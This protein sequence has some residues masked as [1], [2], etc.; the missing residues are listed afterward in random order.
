MRLQE[1]AV[2]IFKI[3]P[4]RSG[5]KKAI[6]RKEILLNGNPAKTSDWIETGQ[7]IE[8]LQ[9]E[10]K[11]KKIYKLPLEVLFEDE[12]L[13]IINKPS[14]IPTSGNYFKTLE[15]TLPF[16]LKTSKAKAALPYALPVHRLDNPTSG[17][18]ICA[19]TRISLTKLQLQIRAK[20]T[21]KTYVAFVKGVPPAQ[22]IY[23]DSIQNKYAK[24]I[25]KR[26]ETVIIK[27]EAF[28]IVN[29]FP[30]TGRTHQIRIHLSQNGFPIIGDK[31]YIGVDYFSVKGILL[32][33]IGL[34]LV[35]PV[36]GE[37]IKIEIPLPQKFL[38][39]KDLAQ[40][41]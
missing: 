3:I 39:I 31:E 27:H 29:L 9:P 38:K 19:K 28:S 20:E 41:P 11:Q 36:T 18:V 32:S 21:Q 16:N 17:L 30:E 35:H 5:I 7:K 33:A 2:S 12:E 4:T 6:K 34:Q 1:Y 26:M 14:G 8:L 23:T 24:T 15:N 37:E 40:N 22:V 10:F 13:A 25:L